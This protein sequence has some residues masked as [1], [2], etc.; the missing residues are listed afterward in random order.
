MK[1]LSCPALAL[2]CVATV[3]TTGCSSGSVTAPDA[4]S[5]ASGDDA[6][7]LLAG[8]VDKVTICHI[9]PGNPE[10]AHTITVGAP[11]VEAHVTL[12]GDT[13]GEC[14]EEFPE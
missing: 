9:P 1:I 4:M 13:I 2:M 7:G 12:H 8:G 11:A 5:A 14:G 3:A 6:A 10:N